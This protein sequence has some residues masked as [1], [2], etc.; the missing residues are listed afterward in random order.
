VR[1]SPRPSAWP[2]D[3]HYLVPGTTLIRSQCDIDGTA[4]LQ[5]KSWSKRQA[6][7]V[8]DWVGPI[9][10]WLSVCVLP[11]PPRSPAQLRFPGAVG[12]VFNIPRLCCPETRDSTVSVARNRLASSKNATRSLASLDFFPAEFPVAD[13]GWFECRQRPVRVCPANGLWRGACHNLDPG[14]RTRK[15]LPA[16]TF[17]RALSARFECDIVLAGHSDWSRETYEAGLDGPRSLSM[18]D[19]LWQSS[20]R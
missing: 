16:A 18:P 6:A 17:V 20:L 9:I 14:K 10:G 13:R 15:R 19:R 11:A 12:I 8:D 5:T 3:P 1:R 2:R 7:A 4:V